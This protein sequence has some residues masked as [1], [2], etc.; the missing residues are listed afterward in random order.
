LVG[1]TG[2]EGLTLRS[3]EPGDG[4]L[5]QSIMGHPDVA[6]WLRPANLT[7]PFTPEECADW[8]RR[9]AAHWDAFGFGEW[10]AFDGDTPVGRGGLGHTVAARRAEV[11]LGWAVAPSHQGR[12][13]ATWLAL[14]GLAVAEERGIEG[15]VAY[16]RADNEASRRTAEKAGLELERAFPHAGFP[17]VLYRKMRPIR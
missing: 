10:M 7:G 1:R 6:R 5:L 14:E 3:F 11:E 16:T 15:V 17:H 8:A 4:P 12:G 9:K 13:I 2:V